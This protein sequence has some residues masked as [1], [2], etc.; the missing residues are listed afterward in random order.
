MFTL[1]LHEFAVDPLDVVA[2]G[3]LSDDLSRDDGRGKEEGGCQTH[4]QSKGT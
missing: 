1:T 2:V 3:K 4:A